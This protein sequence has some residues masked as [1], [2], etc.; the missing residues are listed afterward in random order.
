MYIV[1]KEISTRMMEGYPLMEEPT[2]PDG[3]PESLLVRRLED[4][5]A[6]RNL[7]WVNTEYTR[8]SLRMESER[9][10]GRKGWLKMQALRYLITRSVL[11][12]KLH[13]GVKCHGVR[14]GKTL[15]VQQ[16]LPN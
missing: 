16:P 7:E 14:R 5:F 11:D 6:S 1:P 8:L 9:G 3:T 13:G 4:E 2:G 15:L 12:A 10:I